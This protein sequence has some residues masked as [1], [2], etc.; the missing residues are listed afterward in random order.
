MQSIDGAKMELRVLLNLN[1]I[2]NC[3]PHTQ[4]S[5]AFNLPG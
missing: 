4:M 3:L 2:I 1:F 5:S